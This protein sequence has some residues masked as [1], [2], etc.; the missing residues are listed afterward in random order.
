MNLNQNIKKT[1]Y[2]MNDLT[3]SYVSVTDLIKDSSN[4]TSINNIE[5]TDNINTYQIQMYE[6]SCCIMHVGVMTKLYDTLITEFTYKDKQYA[7]T[8]CLYNKEKLSG[9]TVIPI[10]KIAQVGKESFLSYNFNT[11][12]NVTDHLSTFDFK[13]KLEGVFTVTVYDKESSVI[14]LHTDE[15][16]DQDEAIELL[17]SFI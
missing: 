16:F 13:V 17:L 2:V 4:I 10:F 15:Q 11:N 9:R 12:L 14:V 6:G 5:S 1:A 7:L 3:E 8:S